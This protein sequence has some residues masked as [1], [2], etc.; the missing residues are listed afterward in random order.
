GGLMKNYFIQSNYAKA[1]VLYL[2]H[3]PNDLLVPYQTNRI[4]SGVAQCATQ[5]PFNCQWIVNRP[6]ISGS[7][8]IIS[9]IDALPTGPQKPVYQF[10]STLN[11]SDCLGQ[12]ANPATTGHAIDNY[13]LRSTNM[14]KLFTTNIDTTSN[15]N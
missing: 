4:L 6:F 15:C 1:P 14:A 2:Y 8:S 7:S 3:Q 9:I 10:D 12:Y 11:N 13:W 5:F